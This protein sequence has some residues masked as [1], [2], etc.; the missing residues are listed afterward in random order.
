MKKIKLTTNTEWPFVRQ[1]PDSKGIW[2]D[3]QF[4]IDDNSTECD[5][6]VVFDGLKKPETALCNPKHT[7]LIT[8]EPPSVKTYNKKFL[9]QFEYIVTCHRSFKHKNLIFT[10]QSLPWMVGRKF[11]PQNKSWDKE[12]SKDYD[13]L[14]SIELIVKNKKISLISSAKNF[15]KGHRQRLLFIS[16]IQ[17]VFGDTVDIFGL[18]FKPIADKWDALAPYKY[19]VVLENSSYSDYWTEKLSDALLSET[20][21]IYYGC[22]N[23]YDY[24]PKD[25]LVTINIYDIKNS[26]AQIQKI[27]E[28]D[29]YEKS[30][31]AIIKARNVVLD[32]YNLFPAITNLIE[33]LPKEGLSKKITILPESQPKWKKIINKILRKYV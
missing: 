6:W 22:P 13:E 30:I 19:S 27:I 21:P 20:L 18:G 1:T 29:T 26:I 2:K 24:F 11:I 25:S 28:S 14:S 8:A 31:N 32:K 4:L 7:I 3:C 16:E 33:K 5:W 9:E 23:I 12:S 17:K 10:Q 15:T